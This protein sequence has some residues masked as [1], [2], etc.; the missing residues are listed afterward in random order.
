[1][2]SL[3]CTFFSLFF[4]ARD[5]D[6]FRLPL[7]RPPGPRV[8]YAVLLARRATHFSLFSGGD[9]CVWALGNF[10]GCIPRTSSAPTICQG[11]VRMQTSGTL[12]LV[13]L[14]LFSGPLFS[15]TPKGDS[16]SGPAPPVF[17]RPRRCHPFCTYGGHIA[18]FFDSVGWAVAMPLS[19]LDVRSLEILC[20]LQ[21]HSVTPPNTLANGPSSDTPIVLL[22][23]SP[24][25]PFLSS[26]PRVSPDG[27]GGS[28][29]FRFIKTP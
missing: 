17:F 2:L 14:F 4:S 27:F 9:S 10:P 24:F 26:P 29:T 6:S 19:D 16:A 13:P 22:C 11:G 7:L 1:L 8:L 23:H 12:F 5:I 20:S 3:S 21:P 25:P 18:L 28:W 15:W